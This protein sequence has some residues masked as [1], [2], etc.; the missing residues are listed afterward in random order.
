MLA[1]KYVGQSS[2]VDLTAL[3][4]P[5]ECGGLGDLLGCPLNKNKEM[6]CNTNNVFGLS[7]LPR[8]AEDVCEHTFIN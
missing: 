4:L 5:D 3:Q 8:Y 7:H 6:H 1:E 2:I